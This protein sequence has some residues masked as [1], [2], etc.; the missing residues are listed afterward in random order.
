MLISLPPSRKNPFRNPRSLITPKALFFLQKTSFF[1]LTI[2][3]TK[4]Y[5]CNT[6]QTGRIMPF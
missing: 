3:I 2:C 5:Y 4:V 1:L 6:F